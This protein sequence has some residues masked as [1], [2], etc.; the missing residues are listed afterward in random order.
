MKN[1]KLV[2][3]FIAVGS[4]ALMTSCSGK[5]GAPGP[6]GA[7]GTPG[8]NGTNANAVSAADQAAYDA[9]DGFVGGKLYDN[10]FQYLNVTNPDITGNPGFFRC[11]QCHGW[12]LLGSKGAYIDEAPVAGSS[13]STAPNN[14]MSYTALHNIKEMFDKI[15]NT[16]GRSRLAAT[17]VTLN[18]DHPDFG[19]LLTD[20]QIWDIVKFFKEEALNPYNVYDMQVTGTYPTGTITFTNIGK[21]LGTVAAGDA[22]FA[23]NCAGCHGADGHTIALEGGTM[24]LGDFIRTTPHEIVF[25]AKFGTADNMMPGVSTITEQNVRD[26][27]VAGQD[28]TKYIHF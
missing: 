19:K 9:A 27:L 18:D 25:H 5:D 3:M 14:L 6:A 15:K 28:T 8:A 22:Y 7:D 24:S 26:L 13:P 4:F 2:L 11:K 12:D 21:G 16:G 1:L 23:A 20:A 10:W 17:N